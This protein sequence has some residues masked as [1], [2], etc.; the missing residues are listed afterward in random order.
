MLKN[1]SKRRVQITEKRRQFVKAS[2]PRV[3]IT[4]TR[5]SIARSILGRDPDGCFLRTH[6]VASHG[7]LFYRAKR[8]PFFFSFFFFSSS[9][10]NEIPRKTRKHFG[11]RGNEVSVEDREQN[12]CRVNGTCFRAATTLSL[13]SPFPLSISP[14]LFFVPSPRRDIK[15]RSKPVNV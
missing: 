10:K 4:L 3:K 8:P 9:K 7:V 11:I 15:A 13:S 12:V 1:S 6:R 2:K 14:S 5:S